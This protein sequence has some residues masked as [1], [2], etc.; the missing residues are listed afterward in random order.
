MGDDAAEIWA[1]TVSTGFDG[2]MPTA[3][4]RAFLRGFY[5][6]VS[7]TAF[8]ATWGGSPA[9]AGTVSTHEG[10]GMLF[11]TSTIEGYRSRGLQMRLIHQRIAHAQ[12]RGCDLAM[13]Q[14]TPGSASERNIARAGFQLAYTKLFVQ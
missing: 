2:R 11:N 3:R 12:R 13:V 9:A 6:S 10:V 8:L 14:A 7:T 5:D 1:D 4:D